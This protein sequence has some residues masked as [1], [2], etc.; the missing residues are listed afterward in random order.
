MGKCV[1]TEQWYCAWYIFNSTQNTLSAG[2]YFHIIG[3]RNEGI[4]SVTC[5]VQGLLDS[6]VC[7][8]NIC[9]PHAY[10]HYSLS[11]QSSFQIC[12]LGAF[13][14]LSGVGTVLL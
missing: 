14:L 13:P 7:S 6:S 1:G 4:S 2:S 5:L 3:L 9:P 10:I 8:E 11:E 12:L